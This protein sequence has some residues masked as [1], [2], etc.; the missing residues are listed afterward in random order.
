[1]H[2][3]LASSAEAS[4]NMFYICRDS[5]TASLGMQGMVKEVYSRESGGRA[6]GM[7]ESLIVRAGEMVDFDGKG[8][9]VK[10]EN[11]E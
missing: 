1:M 10:S 8:F 9:H 11:K 3:D 5:R 6:Y 4:T 7:N 2:D